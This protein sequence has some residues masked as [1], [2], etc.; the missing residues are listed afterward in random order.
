MTHWKS[1]LTL[2]A[3]LCCIIAVLML[4]PI[5]QDLN[6]HLFADQQAWL[7]LPNFWNVISNLPFVAVG[8]FGLSR[9]PLSVDAKLLPA[10]WVFC[11][12]MV[13]VGLGSS[14][15]H[16]A[17]S[18]QT[19]I[20]DRLPMSGAFMALFACVIV[21]AISHRARVLLIPLV[22][23]G[24]ASVVYWY[25]TELQGQGDLRPYVLVQFLPLIL[26]PL[27]LLL[28]GTRQLRAHLLWLTLAFYLLA[29][30]AEHYDGEIYTRLGVLSGH[31]LKHLIAA[32]AIFCAVVSFPSQRIVR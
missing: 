18:T 14:Y 2:C 21:D 10:Y 25:W 28:F 8:L 13:L 16:Y 17:P 32:V 27:M 6:Y 22:L 11:A 5:A 3:A 20:W 30:A 15:Y 12:F 26:L 7:G 19:L 4:P 9:P 1:V 24:L 23:G 31:T 29:K